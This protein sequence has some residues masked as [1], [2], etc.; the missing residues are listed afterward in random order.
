MTTLLISD[1]HLSPERPGVTQAFLSFLTHQASTANALYILGDLFEVWVGDDDQSALAKGVISSLKDLTERG[2]ALYFL[3][4]N[5]DF[6]VSKRF[7]RETGC[8][9]LPEHYV[10]HIEG[11]KVLLLHGDT[12]CIEDQDYQH[13]RRKARHPISLWCLHHLP[14][15]TRQKI[16]ENGRAKS[17][18]VNSNKSDNIMDVTNSE[19]ERLMEKHQVN[20]MIH[21]HTHRPSCHQQKH[22]KRFVLGDWHHHGWYLQMTANAEP[23]LCSFPITPTTL[24]PSST[25]S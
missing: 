3:H 11:R 20:I 16:G 25:T 7:A 2:V 6:M 18:A 10:A 8:T 24:S 23:E 13:F 19:V 14:L 1:L 22:G 5:R 4:G 21:G 12:L 9:L 17:M 15:R